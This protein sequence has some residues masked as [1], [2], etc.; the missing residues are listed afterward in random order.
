MNEELLLLS[1]IHQLEQRPP[2]VRIE[3]CGEK[4]RDV[5]WTEM[6]AL[7]IALVNQHPDRE[8]VV[9]QEGGNYR[10]GRRESLGFDVTDDMGRVM[11]VV[12]P[13]M[14]RGGM[15]HD[16]E[17]K[18]DERWRQRVPLAS[19]CKTLAPGRYRV[20]AAY[21]FGS[22]VGCIQ[23]KWKSFM[24][25][26][27]PVEFVVQPR[28]ITVTKAK[29]KSVSEHLEEM[30]LSMP[31]VKQREQQDL[32]AKL[33]RW[34]QAFTGRSEPPLRFIDGKYDP[35]T[36]KSFIPPESPAGQLLQLGWVAVP[37]MIDV[38]GDEQLHSDKRAW[39]LALLYSITGVNDPRSDYMVAWTDAPAGV[40]LSYEYKSA[41]GWSVVHSEESGEPA[42]FSMG[43][44]GGGRADSS[45]NLENQLRFAKRWTKCRNYLQ[46]R[47][48]DQPDRQ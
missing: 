7:E 29:Q 1:A 9:W 26:S 37:S 2:P 13:S 46:V 21:A 11:P 23:D 31:F 30:E 25:M 16:V 40:L 36:H 12:V 19:Y 5:V 20:R 39:I 44:G 4:S 43:F 48:E 27:N 10:H 8:T 45:V 15:I 47:G 28:E 38:L 33:G 42:S 41:R 3:I 34:L 17:L 35:E 32:V 18:V 14:M 24:I 6:P 22:P